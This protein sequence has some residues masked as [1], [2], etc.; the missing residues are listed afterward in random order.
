MTYFDYS[1]WL[2]SAN[3]ATSWHD[4]DPCTFTLENWDSF[5]SFFRLAIWIIIAVQGWE[6][7]DEFYIR[8]LYNHSISLMNNPNCAIRCLLG[9]LFKQ[10]PPVSWC[11]QSTAVVTY[12]FHT[13]QFWTQLSCNGTSQFR[14]CLWGSDILKSEIVIIEKL[15]YQHVNAYPQMPFRSTKMMVIT[16][17]LWFWIRFRTGRMASFHFQNDWFGPAKLSCNL[18]V[19]GTI[20]TGWLITSQANAVYIFQHSLQTDIL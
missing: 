16:S 13:W 8:L 1:N 9:P 19:N 14:T 15:I 12:H 10:I 18:T 7:D 11:S 5:V 20:Q 17:Y 4:I 6:W 3:S 2:C